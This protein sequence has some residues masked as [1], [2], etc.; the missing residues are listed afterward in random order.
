M[1]ILAIDT[2]SQ[3]CSVCLCDNENLLSEITIVPGRTH[4]RHLM[5]II[6]YVLKS[7]SS[8]L[9]DVHGFAVTKGPGSFTGLRIGIST[10]KGLGLALNKPVVGIS[11]L[12][13]LAAPFYFTGKKVYSLIDARKGEIYWASYIA[14]NGEMKQITPEQSSAPYEIIFDKEPAIF[15]GSGVEPCR[16]IIE[17]NYGGKA[18]C[19]PKSFNIIKSFFVAGLALKRFINNEPDNL[20]TFAPRYIRK[21]DAEIFF[22]KG[23]NR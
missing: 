18:C 2:S 19:A 22:N 21:S 4:S 20:V 11:T 8:D 16:K 7:A 5:E 23:K 9:K 14:K 10:I 15:V 3:S 12:L 13:A 17:K 6:D 1:K